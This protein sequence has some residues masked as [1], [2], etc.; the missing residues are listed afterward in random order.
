[1]S[2][3]F[4]VTEVPLFADLKDEQLQ[5]QL[6]ERFRSQH[7][8]AGDILCKEGEPQ[9]A[10]FVIE[11]GKVQR[12]KMDVGVVDELGRGHIS[13]MLH[14]LSKGGA[15]ATLEVVEPSTVWSLSQEDFEELLNLKESPLAAHLLKSMAEDMRRHSKLLRQTLGEQNKDERFSIVF[16]DARP[17]EKSAFNEANEERVQDKKDFRITYFPQR[18]DGDT[19]YLAEGHE[20]VCIF[21][22]DVCDATVVERLANL[23]VK[24]IALR[25]AGFNNVDLNACKAH[26]ITVVRVP[27]YSPYAVAEHAIALMLCLNRKIHRAYNRTREANFELDGLLGFDMHG[28]TVGVFGT[29][30]IGRCVIDILLGFGC[31]CLCF[32]KYPSEEVKNTKNCQY[33]ELDEL[34]AKSDIITLHCPLTPETEHVIN[35]SAINKMKSGVMIINTSRGAVID[36]NALIKGL[37]SKKIG[38]AGLDVYEAEREYF[39]RDHSKEGIISDETL[40]RLMTFGNV[41]LT[42]HQAFF[43]KEALEGI[44]NVTLDNVATFAFD[45]KRGEDHP[46]C[47][48]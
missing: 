10:M 36:T 35:D 40:A 47:V 5:K 9:P 2:H 28:K 24:L 13:G 26:G 18:L 41:L 46:N 1:M 3:S 21:V 23:G 22:N 27:A 14:L 17:Y 33:V 29:G 11:T 37:K 32:D 30:K 8:K 38:A 15:F 34:F 31:K 20:C 42:G 4:L 43:T 45:E 48:K 6:T 44:V 39:F 19:A 25:S 12:K 7:Y 16:F